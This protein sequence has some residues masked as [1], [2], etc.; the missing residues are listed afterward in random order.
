[1]IHKRTT[2]LLAALVAVLAVG[3]G[4]LAAGAATG[5]DAMQ[6][7][8]QR[9]RLKP[10]CTNDPKLGSCTAIGSVTGFINKLGK[11]KKPFVAPSN[12]KIVA[13][14][15]EL[16]DRPSNKVPPG[17]ETSNLQFFRDTFGN[18]EYGDDPVARISILK[19]VEGT[20]FKLKRN[21]PDVAI[22]GSFYNQDT[23]ITLAKPL[24]IQKGEVVA[25]SSMTWLPNIKESNGGNTNWR[26]K[27]NA[28]KCQ[29]S[30][31]LE[32]TPHRGLKTTRGYKCSFD[33]RLFYS[34]Y[35]VPKG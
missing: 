14:G 13:W 24:R 34:A 32:T 4:M 7:G 3:V 20:R 31:T 29:E 17:E 12:G 6:F 19:R 22:P 18:D 27:G 28:S 30:A 21:S 9:E 2:T 23:T 11:T 8:K 33:D 1:M 25:L 5:A 10:D 35:F 15:L 26:A 16:R